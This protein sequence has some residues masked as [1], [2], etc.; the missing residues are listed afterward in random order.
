MMMRTFIFTLLIAMSSAW[1][2]EKDLKDLYTN[3]TTSINSILL[4]QEGS[5]EMSGFLSYNYLNSEFENGSERT[6]SIIQLEPQFS[7]FVA[8]N[9]SAGV[10]LSYSRN[11]TEL[12]GGDVTFEQ[13][14]AGP[15][16]KMYFGEKEIRPFIFTDFLFLSGDSDGSEADFGAGIFYHVSG[17]FGLNLFG[18]YG[19]LWQNNNM[20]ESQQ[21]IFIGIGFTNFIL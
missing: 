21:R 17:N 16:L 20:I 14:L 8:D 13:T 19:I 15:L 12:Q 5:M 9:I 6:Q 10:Q 4:T 1:A 2:Q 3:F 11:Q 18:K 7:Y